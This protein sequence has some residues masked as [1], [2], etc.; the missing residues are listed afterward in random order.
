MDILS[1]QKIEHLIGQP[2]YKILRLSGG[3][4][5]EVYRVDLPDNTCIVAKVADGTS[6]SLDSEGYMLRYLKRHSRLP[7]PEVL[8]S[9]PTLLLMEFIEGDSHLNDSAQH[10]AAKLLADLHSVR[11]QAF[12]LERDTLI[13]GLHQPNPQYEQWIPFFREQRL[14]YMG[15]EALRVGRLPQSVFARLE[16]FSQHLD[17]WL[18]EPEYPSLIHGDMWT[19][20][21]LAKAGRITGFIDPAIYY[22]HPE[23]ELAFSTLF[24]TFG[25]LFFEQYHALYPIEPGFFEERRDIYN[26][27]PLLVHVRLFGG[28]YVE[29]VSQILQKFGY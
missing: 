9:S 16:R 3:C 19:T 28:G 1:H 12:G 2:V 14:L 10:H 17:K 25:R 4:I 21:I 5:G 20:N 22:A 7:V 26:L 23:I 11:G 18:L 24:G 8:H 27:Y 29:S 13:G 15:E 6:A